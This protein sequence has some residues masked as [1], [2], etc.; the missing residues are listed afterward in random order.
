[1]HPCATSWQVITTSRMHILTV[2]HSTKTSGKTGYYSKA[3]WYKPFSCGRHIG[4]LQGNVWVRTLSRVIVLTPTHTAPLFS[5]L[6]CISIVPIAALTRFLPV[7]FLYLSIR[8]CRGHSFGRRIPHG[9]EAL[10]PC[11]S[12]WIVMHEASID[13][14]LLFVLLRSAGSK[15]NGRIH[16]LY[17][18]QRQIVR[19]GE[20]QSRTTSFPCRHDFDYLADQSWDWVRRRHRKDRLHRVILGL[21]HILLLSPRI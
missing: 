17:S 14:S 7:A 13:C 5:R 19:T 4:P 15:S 6:P 2:I 21:L 9:L 16:L 18:L 12:I 8:L 20:Y 1:M 3:L 11:E 10:T